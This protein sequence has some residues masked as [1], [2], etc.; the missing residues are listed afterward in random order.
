MTYHVDLL[1]HAPESLAG[2][3]VVEERNPLSLFYMLYFLG[4]SKAGNLWFDITKQD[5][6]NNESVGPEEFDPVP[7]GA[8]LANNYELIVRTML[9]EGNYSKYELG[10]VVPRIQKVLQQKVTHKEVA[11]VAGRDTAL[12]VNQSDHSALTDEEFKAKDRVIKEVRQ[13]ILDALRDN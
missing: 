7:L 3:V 9:G 11:L 5:P 1:H 4:S 10:K 12:R 8:A 6:T 13:K 2:A